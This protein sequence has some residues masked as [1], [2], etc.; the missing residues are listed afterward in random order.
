M[1]AHSHLSDA[2]RIRLATRDGD[3]MIG[4]KERSRCEKHRRRWNIYRWVWQMP[5]PGETHEDTIS[6]S[7][8]EY[9]RACSDCEAEAEQDD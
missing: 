6:S 3:K 9:V 2:D 1:A 7:E 5:A 4:P 8:P